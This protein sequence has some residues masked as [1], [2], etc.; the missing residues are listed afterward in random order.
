MSVQQLLALIAD[1]TLEDDLGRYAD[2]AC[3]QVEALGDVEATQAPREVCAN[4]G[5]AADGRAHAIAMLGQWL[6]D[7]IPTQPVHH[8]WV[9]VRL[10]WYYRSNLRKADYARIPLALIAARKEIEGWYRV[11]TV[12]GRKMTFYQRPAPPLDL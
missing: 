6:R 1:P 3:S 7:V 8:A 4:V 11:E 2:I 5:D 9:A 10:V 12:R